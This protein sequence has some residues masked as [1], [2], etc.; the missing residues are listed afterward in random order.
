IFMAASGAISLADGPTTQPAPQTKRVA[1]VVTTYFH[2]SHADMIVS[3][4]LET[5]TLDGKGKTSPL[6]LAS[7]YTDQVHAKDIS[8]EFAKKYD[9]PIY[10]TVENALTLG[11]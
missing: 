6:K 7:L 4:L 11:T 8:R 2:N 5:D 9:F 3:R 10:D 1:A